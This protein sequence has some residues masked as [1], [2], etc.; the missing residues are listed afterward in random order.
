MKKI[1]LLLIATS[2]SGCWITDTKSKKSPPSAEASKTRTMTQ[3]ADDLR[4]SAAIHI[5]LYCLDLYKPID[6]K[7]K[8]GVVYYTGSVPSLKESFAASGI[9]W[10]QNGVRDVVND[11]KIE[12]KDSKKNK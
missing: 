9:A 4:I 3:T 6:V 2:L 8:D 12:K 7:V 5:D 11:L 1:L 10:K